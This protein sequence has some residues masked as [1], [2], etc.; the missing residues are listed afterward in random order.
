MPKCTRPAHLQDAPVTAARCTEPAAERCCAHSHPICGP[1]VKWRWTSP[2]MKPGCSPAP[3]WEALLCQRYSNTADT[4]HRHLLVL[5]SHCCTWF[6]VK[7]CKIS[8]DVLEAACGMCQAVFSVFRYWR[9]LLCPW[10][11]SLVKENH[12]QQN[13]LGKNICEWKCFSQCCC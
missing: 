1:W 9:F 8:F 12:L 7:H 10:V 13:H 5:P 3:T 4:A 6:W 11:S 2:A